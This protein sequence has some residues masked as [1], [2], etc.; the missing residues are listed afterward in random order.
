VTKPHLDSKVEAAIQ[1]LLQVE[2]QLAELQTADT[3]AGVLEDAVDD[4]SNNKKQTKT[5]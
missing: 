5:L 2:A 1:W 4:T 3:P